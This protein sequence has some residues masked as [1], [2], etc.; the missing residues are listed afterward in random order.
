MIH[1]LRFFAQMLTVVLVVLPMTAFGSVEN[2][3]ETPRAKG[4]TSTKSNEE[5]G[6][7]RTVPY[8]TLRNKTGSDEAEH[9]FGEERNGVHTGFCDLSSTPLKIMKPLAEK[10]PFYIPDDIVR[11]HAIREVFIEDFWRDIEKTANSRRL[12]LYTHGYNIDFAKG[13]KRASLFQENLGLAGRFLLFSWPSHGTVLNYTRDES[14]LYWSVAPLTEILTGMINRFGAGN[15]DVVA[16]SLG[17]R[18][19][20]LALVQM[21]HGESANKPL[22]HQ[23]VLIAP[24][25]DGGIFKQYAPRIQPLARHTTIYVSDN[26]RPLALS[27]EVH[28]YPRLGQ[29]GPHLKGLAGIE[30]IDVSDI[31]TRSPSGHVYHLYHPI[32]ADDV[33]QLLNDG[34]LASQRS[35]LRQTGKDHWRLQPA[36]RTDS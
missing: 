5:D 7:L 24:D 23:L 9:F 3:K 11:L 33:S 29:P 30:F 17:A 31:G 26:D 36:D 15:L 12:V 28:G 2:N 18:G 32:M 10:A 16:H 21:A 27:E 4:T 1:Q 13:C 34:K 19:V 14:D 8:I 6:M 20:I 35:N 25:I 22:M